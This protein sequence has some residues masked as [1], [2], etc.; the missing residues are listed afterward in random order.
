VPRDQP[1]SAGRRQTATLQA[2]LWEYQPNITLRSKEWFLLIGDAPRVDG[3]CPGVGHPLVAANF[4]E[5]APQGTV[6]VSDDLW[7]GII[8]G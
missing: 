1:I 4:Q 6:P 2:T 8:V 5:A 3:R 7:V